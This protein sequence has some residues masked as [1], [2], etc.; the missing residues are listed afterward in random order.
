M[1]PHCNIFA[2]HCPRITRDRHPIIDDRAGWLARAFL[3]SLVRARGVRGAAGL[4]EQAAG[5]SGRTFRNDRAKKRT[6]TEIEG[7]AKA[8]SH[9][10]KWQPDRGTTRASDAAGVHTIHVIEC[11]LRSEG[12]FGGPRARFS[13][14][15]SALTAV[16]RAGRT[17]RTDSYVNAAK[18]LRSGPRSAFQRRSGPHV[19]LVWAVGRTDG[20]T[21]CGHGLPGALQVA[22]GRG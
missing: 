8:R 4:P 21:P 9:P 17:S 16:R 12:R 3:R 19:Q 10:P 2:R 13:A 6:R 18:Q 20:H 14:R 1:P 15:L 7:T 22:A 5:P 11:V